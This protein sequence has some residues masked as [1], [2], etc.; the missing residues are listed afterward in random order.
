MT[1][2]ERTTPPTV[3]RR[4]FLQMTG[5]LA[6]G[7]LLPAA[8][9]PAAGTAGSF[10]VQP[11]RDI[12]RTTVTSSISTVT[13]PAA[14]PASEAS[15]TN[16]SPPAS[17]PSS[18][19][20]YNP[21]DTGTRREAMPDLEMLCDFV[22]AL[23][24]DGIFLDTLSHGAAEFRTLLDAARP[25]V[26]L[27]SELA[28]QVERVH[29]HHFSW[30]QWFADSYVPGVLRNKWFEPRHLQHQIKRWDHGHS[31][32]LHTAWMNGSGIMVWENVFGS[33]VGWNARDRSILRSMLPIQRRFKSLWHEGRW[34]PLV[35]TLAPDVYAN[36]WET[37]GLR[38]WTL[39][40]RSNR[41]IR[42]PLLPWDATPNQRCLD[43]V[44]GEQ[45]RNPPREAVAPCQARPFLD[46]PHPG[47]QRAVRPL[48]RINRIPSPSTGEFSQTL[49][50]F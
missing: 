7:V 45:L 50:P 31:G 38:L 28:L 41:D 48:S 15:F 18:I 23:D 32:E 43:L 8:N 16:C 33:W 39:I 2:P 27:E 12:I 46:G 6:G 25:G 42:G 4:R 30:A 47:D 21:W 1:P 37:D 40:N 44:A 9:V 26:A 35:S 36:L 22:R 20:I 29:D 19:T 5:T 34:T 14:S 24:V 13:C 49:E 3:N 10:V 11:E 17:G